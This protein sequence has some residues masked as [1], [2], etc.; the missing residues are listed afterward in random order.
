MS[1]PTHDADGAAHFATPRT[2]DDALPPAPPSGPEEAAAHGGALDFLHALASGFPTEKI[3]LGALIDGCADRAFGFVL[4]VLAIPCCVPF[5]YGIPQL[6]AVPMVLIAVQIAIGRH[7]PWLP[8]AL[9]AREI[10]REGFL[11]V[12]TRARKYLGWAEKIT[13]ARAS[14]LTRGV[15]ERFFGALMVIYSAVILVPLPSTNT[16]P[17]IAIAIM[18]LGFIERDGFLVV[19]GSLIGAA[20]VTF[21]VSVGGLALTQALQWVS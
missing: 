3:S 4:L 8:K 12:V 21:L 16:V 1:T 5:L 9:R 19:L 2:P 17:G 10:P 20:W 18:S 11:E 15:W 7:T 6:V 14:F 13:N